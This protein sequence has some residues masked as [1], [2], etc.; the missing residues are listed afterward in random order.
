MKAIC[1]AGRVTMPVTRW[2]VVCA[3]ADV[4]LTLVPTRRFNKV[5]L[6][7]LG[8]PTIATAPAR[9][10]FSALGASGKFIRLARSILF[11]AAPAGALSLRA[12]PKLGDNALHPELLLMRFAVGRDD[13][14][15]RER[16]LVL[17]KV[18]LQQCLGIFPGCCGI[19]GVEQVTQQLARGRARGLEAAV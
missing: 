18:F 10:V 15:L 6:P 7:T 3:L 8:R 17:L 16:E 9:C 13:G 5:D 19:N 1:P 2:R 12:D 4:M 14:I 11:G